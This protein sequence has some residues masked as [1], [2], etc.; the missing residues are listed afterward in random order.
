[1]STLFNETE[2]DAFVNKILVQHGITINKGS[3]KMHLIKHNGKIVKVTGFDQIT[4]DELVEA[5]AV[6]KQRLDIAEANLAE[7]DNLTDEPS[8]VETQENTEVETSTQDQNINVAQSEPVAEPVA[9]T[10]EVQ[11]PEQPQPPTL[12]M[13]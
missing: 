4:R 5:V 9:H 11:T 7:F 3:G 8:D 6:A 1:M 13:Q 10:I 2:A 12:V